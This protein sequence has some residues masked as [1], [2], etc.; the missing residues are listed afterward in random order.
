MSISKPIRD[1]SD[2]MNQIARP[3]RQAR[4][5][6]ALA[7]N[8]LQGDFDAALFADDAAVFHGLYLPHKHS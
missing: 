1:G 5:A 3:A 6:H 7:A 2:F 4:Y 8:L